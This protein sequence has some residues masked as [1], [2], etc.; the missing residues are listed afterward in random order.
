MDRKIHEKL[1]ELEKKVNDFREMVETRV[2]RIDNDRHIQEDILRIGLISLEKKMKKLEGLQQPHGE[3]KGG[4]FLEK[5]ALL[6]ERR[7][8]TEN[9]LKNKIDEL[10]E[11]IRKLEFP[12]GEKRSPSDNGPEKWER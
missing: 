11:R 9:S 2:G 10:E 5:W 8:A 1:S 6:E 7:I 12:R 3:E 4:D